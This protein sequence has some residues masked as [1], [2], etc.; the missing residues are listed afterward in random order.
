MA[1]QKPMPGSVAPVTLPKERNP[2]LQSASLV[3]LIAECV[4]RLVASRGRMSGHEV[5]AANALHD[6]L[7]DCLDVITNRFSIKRYRDML[8]SLFGAAKAVDRIEGARTLDL[9]CGAVNPLAFSFLLL[10]LG[11]RRGV[12]VDAEPIADPQ[13]AAR[14]LAE[15]A[16]ALQIDPQRILEGLLELPLERLVPRLDGFDLAALSRGESASVPQG[17]LD[18]VQALAEDLPFDDA[19]FDIVMSFS[20]LE[21]VASADE[22]ATELARVTAPGGLHMHVVDGTDH[23]RFRDSRID[24]LEFLGD[25]TDAPILHGSNRLRRSELAKSFERAGFV[26][27]EL[28]TF[29]SRPITPEQRSRF[30]EPFR[31][32]DLSELEVLH[33]LMILERR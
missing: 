19:S 26:C 7:H 23:R 8:H 24:P 4:D 21:H 27:R 11:A 17:R 14:A 29:F 12:A 31:S 25:P 2:Q 28:K 22:V 20:F 15:V 16:S 33:W 5:N 9:G 1:E 10:L 30:V 3:E 18:F 13:R 32:M 6:S